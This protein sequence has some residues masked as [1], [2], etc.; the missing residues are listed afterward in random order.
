MAASLL[1]LAKSIYYY[2][3]NRTRYHFIL[4]TALYEWTLDF[5]RKAD[6]IKQ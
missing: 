5:L 4:I 2:Y 1:A 6:E 3:F